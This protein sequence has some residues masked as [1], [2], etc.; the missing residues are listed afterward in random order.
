MLVCDNY[1]SL[2][3]ATE[4]FQRPPWELDESESARLQELLVSQ[5]ALEKRIVRYAHEAGITVAAEALAERLATLRGAYEEE[6]SWLASLE[7]AGLTQESFSAAIGRE[8]LMEAV[9]EKVVSAVPTLSEEGARAWYLDHPRQFLRP[10]RRRVRHILITINE[11]IV[12]NREPVA[13]RRIES[14]RARLIGAPQRFAELAERH[15][16]CPSAVHGGEIGWVEAGQLY[17]ELDSA[18]FTLPNEGL[19]GILTSPMGYHLVLCCGIQEAAPIP[20]EQA[21]PK[22]I[23]AHHER[24]KAK[25]QKQWLNWLMQQEFLDSEA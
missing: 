23:A 11:E 21:V 15:S 24:A 6:S 17:P 4:H 12:D 10:E 25:L 7:Q 2:K 8:L 18:L 16:E 1:V 5:I 3:L 22:I 9:L 13:R 19:S 14:L 20:M